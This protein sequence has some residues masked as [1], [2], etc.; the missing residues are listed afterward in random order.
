M[1]KACRGSLPEITV[2]TVAYTNHTILPE[3]LENGPFP[4]SRTLAANLFNY[5]RN[6]QPLAAEVRRHPGD[7]NKARDVAI[8]GTADSCSLVGPRQS[9][10][11]RRRRNPLADLEGFDAPS[12][13]HLFP[14]ALFQ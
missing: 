12:V 8:C 10:R 7:E 2:R 11:Q 9:Q 3:A 1:K 4:C 6:Q 13:L 14:A 5:R